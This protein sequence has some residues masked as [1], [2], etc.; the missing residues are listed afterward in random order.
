[1]PERGDTSRTL[2]TDQ[3]RLRPRISAGGSAAGLESARRPSAHCNF[4]T[5]GVKSFADD[6]AVRKGPVSRRVALLLRSAEGKPF[7]API[8]QAAAA[9]PRARPLPGEQHTQHATNAAGAARAQEARGRERAR[10]RPAGPAGASRVRLGWRRGYAAVGG[11][12]CALALCAASRSLL[13]LQGSP[14]GQAGRPPPP[15]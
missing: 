14:A 12:P 9:A 3:N 2:Q 10:E 7:F 13:A 5:R 8:S 6:L 4:H 15:W 1:M 11:P